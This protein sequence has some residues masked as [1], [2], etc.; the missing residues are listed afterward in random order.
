MIIKT[1]IYNIAL[2]FKFPLMQIMLVQ[3]GCIYVVIG[4]VIKVLTKPHFTSTLVVTSCEYKKNPFF[5][6]C[7]LCITPTV[8]QRHNCELNTEQALLSRDD[9][10]EVLVK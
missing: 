1:L 3:L 8:A 7:V 4:L 5:H 2:S 6:A 9:I 10:I